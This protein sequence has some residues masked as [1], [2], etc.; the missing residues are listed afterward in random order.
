MFLSELKILDH[1]LDLLEKS[2]HS[3]VLANSASMSKVEWIV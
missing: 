3:E 1:F 2:S